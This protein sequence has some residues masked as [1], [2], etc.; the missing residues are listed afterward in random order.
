MAELLVAAAGSYIGNSVITG[1]VMGLTGA[2]LGWGVG[3]MVG[4]M[5][6]GPK[7]PDGPRLDD[8]SVQVSGFGQMLPITYGTVRHAGNV[9]WAADLKEHE[10]SSGGKGKGATT[11][12][13][14]CSFAVSFGEGPVDGI[15]RM[16]FDGNLVYNVRA[17]NDGPQRNF[18]AAEYR[19][20]LGTETQD[21]D[22]TIQAAMTHTPAY[23]GQVYVVF[24]DL[25]L[26]KY[27][28]R[29]PNIEA[30]IAVGSQVIPAAQ[31]IVPAPDGSLSPGYALAIDENTGYVWSGSATS[32]PTGQIDDPAT[33]QRVT[34]FSFSYSV[35]QNAKPIYCPPTNTFWFTGDGTLS[36]QVWVVSATTLTE[37][38]TFTTDK[39][40]VAYNPAT[41][42][43]VATEGYILQSGLDEINPATY[44]VVGTYAAPHWLYEMHYVEPHQY[45]VGYTGY[46]LCIFNAVTLELLHTID[47]PSGTVGAV[48]D[49]ASQFVSYDSR[50]DRLLWTLDA[51]SS[52]L[53][54]IDL[55]G[56]SFTVTD[57][58][59]P[60]WV[61]GVVYHEPSDTYL[62]PSGTYFGSHLL[63]QFDPDTFDLIGSYQTKAEGEDFSYVF[64]I[65]PAPGYDDRVYAK[66]AYGLKVI[67]IKP[68]LNPSG[69]P[70]SEVVTAISERV[71]LDA[72]RLDVSQ[73][74]E[75]VMGYA[76]ARQAT[77][78]SLIEQLMVAYQF[79]AVESGNQVKFVLR[80]NRTVRTIAVEDL[81]AHPFGDQTPAPLEITRADEVELPKTLTIRYLN[82]EA[83]YQVGAQSATRQS[84]S[85]RSETSFDLPIVMKDAKAKAVAE[86]ALYSAWVGRTSVKFSTG[87]KHQAIEPTDVV[88]ADGATVRVV[89]KTLD[90]GVLRFEAALDNAQVFASAA[91]AAPTPAGS[92]Q[93]EVYVATPTGA[94]YLDIPLLRDTDN[95]AGFYIAAAGY[96]SA[97]PGCSVFESSDSGSS[98]YAIANLFNA[99]EIGAAINALDAF[100]AN[101]VDEFN[102]L[103]VRLRFDDGVGLSSVTLAQMLNGGNLALVGDELLQFRTATL[104]PDGSY[105][106]TGLLRGRKGTPTNT[107]VAG[108]R[109]LL[110]DPATLVRH[111]DPAGDRNL[112]RHYKAVTF[113]TALARATATAFTNTAV[114]LQPL[115]PVQLGGG[116]DAAG[117]LTIQWVRRARLAAGWNNGS[118]VP[119]GEASESYSVDVFTDGSF[120]TVKR[121]LSSTTPSV[122]YTAAQQTTDFGSPQASVYLRVYQVSAAV[123]RGRALQGTV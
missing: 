74:T 65:E 93:T 49:R 19:E 101:L 114:G 81:G 97:W 32:P 5:L 75:E 46:Q 76:I 34:N 4:S 24:T 58:T 96:N 13:Y 21:V 17:D 95:D 107:H 45:L 9:I 62:C 69:V 112:A 52:T 84:G 26:A 118:D 33:G 31:Y 106:L 67:Y 119:L 54:T 37:I 27:G 108:E 89:G 39:I 10:H 94:L 78:R 99:S 102:A 41:G 18:T 109:F 38:A 50:R 43:M 23:R 87:L 117:N 64:N 120:A 111:V 6:F 14:T 40:V 2:Q 70:L 79:D 53:K 63:Y 73:L 51:N 85:A 121:T 80:G 68:R 15:V 30:E 92:S 42:N 86:A 71:G 77:A 25:E 82:Y 1:T 66:N 55:A 105:A 35:G 36:T 29:I 116:R 113:N 90:G 104:N 44:A 72:A 59:L 22:P 91:A 61:N 60:H 11:Y 123:G 28:N 98:Y 8:L 110:I 88:V 3:A 48:S 122:S 57:H 83:D 7:A 56:G 115:A 16:W 103:Q 47:Y 20:Y 12:T 100:D